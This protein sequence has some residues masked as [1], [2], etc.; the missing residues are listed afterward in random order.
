MACPRHALGRRAEA[1]VAA[2]LVGQGWHVLAERWRCPQGELDLVATDPEGVLVGIEVK[3]RFSMRAGRGI[4][5]VGA[6]RLARLRAALRAYAATRHRGRAL[7]VDL[8]TLTAEPGGLWRLM[9]LP[10][11]DAW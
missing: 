9:R 2:W 3:V 11:A 8:I 10:A 7:R 1:T 6:R 4:D 5:A